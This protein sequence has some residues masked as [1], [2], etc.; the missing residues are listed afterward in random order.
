[1]PD[2]KTPREILAGTPQLG[3]DVV[4]VSYHGRTVD[5]HTPVEATASE[6]APIRASDPKGLSV[7]RHS[8]AHV[9]A[10]AVQRLFPGTKV[11]IAPAIEDA[12]FYDFAKPAP[13]FTATD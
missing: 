2:R 9:M 6:L 11:T 5:L 4:A 1:M 13:G 10:D 3:E 8:T 12:F 7:I